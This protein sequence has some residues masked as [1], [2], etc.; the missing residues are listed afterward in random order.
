MA[1]AVMRLLAALLLLASVSAHAQSVKTTA[2]LL[3]EFQTCELRSLPPGCVT[4]GDVADVIAT[5]D[6]RIPVSGGGTT[7]FLRADGT[8][9]PPAGGGSV[10]IT[11]LDGSI[12]VAPSPLTGTGTIT[13]G[14]T[15]VAKGGTGLTSGTSG[16]V[17]GYTASGVLALSAALTANAIVLGGGAGATPTALGSLGTTTTVLHGAA[18]GPPT[19]GAVSLATDVSGNLP[20]ANLN[21]GSGA[22]S[23]TCWH[24]DATW[25]A[26]GGITGPGSATSNGF[27]LFNGTTGGIIKDAGFTVI[28]GT[29]GGTG[30]NNGSDTITLGGNISTAGA[31]TTSGAYSATLAFTG[32]TNVTFPTSGTLSTTVGTVTSITPGAGVASSNAGSTTPITSSGTLYVDASYF[33]MFLGGLTLAN[34]SG[35][36]N[37]VIDVAAGAAASDDG[38]VMMKLG[39]FTKNMNAA[40]AAGS[41]NGC[42]DTGSSLGAGLSYFI[43]EIE[44]PDTG[45]VDVLCSAQAAGGTSVTLPSNYTKKRR[46]GSVQTDGSS[47]ILAFTQ[48]GNIFYL[49]TQVLAKNDTSLSTTR[50]LETLAGMPLGV[51]TIP[52][53]RYSVAGTGNAVLLTSS[54]ETDVAPSAATP[55]TA[56]PGFDQLD[57]TLTSGVQN[58]ACPMLTTNT[59]GQIGARATAS[60]TTLSVVLRGWID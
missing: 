40:W 8:W 49:A 59:S 1:G 55:M 58:T 35:T 57:T 4:P 42:L 28:P 18:A 32:A 25:G 34:D 56:A 33:P 24:G 9:A 50:V 45:G 54:D 13:V 48:V 17:L 31:I 15:P 12:V 21:S 2:Q 30:V 22:S 10:S 60:S 19:F 3:T 5:F 29:A 37:T 16:G 39:A 47:H 26:C 43:L 20:V 38:T 14:L 46:I 51:Q 27:V 41:G 23:T 36:P 44:R 11:A 7:N 53:C 52:L 6:A